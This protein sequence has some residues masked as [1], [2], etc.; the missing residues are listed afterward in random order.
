MHVSFNDFVVLSV[1]SQQPLRRP[2]LV[3][4]AVEVFPNRN[5]DPRVAG[6]S[7]DRL[8]ALKLVGY[9]LNRKLQ[10]TEAGLKEIQAWTGVLDF[11]S[12]TCRQL[13]F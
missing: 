4:R 11:A 2:D 7:V 12:K 10:P 6:V 9:D 8:L 3:D 13:T 5:F 1:S